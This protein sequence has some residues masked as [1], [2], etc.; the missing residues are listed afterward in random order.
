[1]KKMVVMNEEGKFLV[2]IKDM[3]C[4][5]G[6]A[7]EEEGLICQLN[8]EKVNDYEFFDSIK[9][10]RE[11]EVIKNYIKTIFE[12]GYT[13]VAVGDNDNGEFEILIDIIEDDIRDYDE[14]LDEIEDTLFDLIE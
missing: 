4:Y 11:S 3:N 2:D 7:T 8:S 13:C 9:E 1:M 12:L 14:L 6:A 5:I 10:L